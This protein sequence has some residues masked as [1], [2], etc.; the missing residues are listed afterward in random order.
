MRKVGV[1]VYYTDMVFSLFPK[2]RQDESLA[3]LIDVGSASVGAA[4]IRLGTGQ[5][6]KILVTNRESIPFQETLS[7]ERFLLA[8]NHT[9]ERVL[10][11]TQAGLMGHGSPKH[12]FC[13]L[14]SPWFLLK[15]RVIRIARKENF[16]VTEEILSGYLDDDIEKLKEE[17]KETL[18]LK[19]TVVIEKKII[20][21]KLNGYEIRNPYGQ[22]T[23][24]M[25]MVATISLSSKKVIDSIKRKVGQFFHTESL[26]F[27]VF[28]IVAFSTIRDI[29]PNEKNFLFLDVTGEATD[30]SLSN[31]DILTGA[32][33][34]PRGKNFFIREISAHFWTMHE[35]ASTLFSMFLKDTLD[36]KRRATVSNI[37]LRSRSEWITRF[38]KVL[39]VLAKEGVI[40]HTVFLTSDS[41]VSRLF[42]DLI[43]GAK[44]D[45]LMT[46][47]F[48][49]RYLDELIVAKFVSFESGAIRD[50]FL[51]VEAL[52]VDKLIK[53]GFSQ[54]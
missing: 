49:A 5:V 19:D 41:D 34:F 1:G 4:L 54:K 3:L 7:S 20:Q 10:K 6:P 36:A 23:T 24:E 22:T 28:P 39:T 35:E 18:P 48:E 33:S 21:M 51:V 13:T 46:N 14:S 37:V 27:G 43:N 45:S 12:I 31:N 8:M 52:F 17:L 15:S 47:S 50:P 2:Q 30:V 42:T 26:H 40:P 32:L 29:F 25:E 16:K 9:L 11:T 44:S 53:T 38:E